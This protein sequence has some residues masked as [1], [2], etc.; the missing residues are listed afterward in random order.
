VTILCH[1]CRMVHELESVEE[2]ESCPECDSEDFRVATQ[3]E[4]S[5]IAYTRWK[6]PDVEP[7]DRI[8][9]EVAF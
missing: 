6:H 8:L 4:E 9:D 3:E 7:Y 5:V 2:P 1:K